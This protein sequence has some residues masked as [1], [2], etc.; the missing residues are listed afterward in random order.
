MTWQD[1]IS[2]KVST[3]ADVVVHRSTGRSPSAPTA[4]HHAIARGDSSSD[5]HHPTTTLIPTPTTAWRRHNVRHL[6]PRQ[7]QVLTAIAT[8]DRIVG[9]IARRLRVTP[10][11]ASATVARLEQLGYVVREKR[12]DRRRTWVCLTSTGRAAVAAYPHGVLP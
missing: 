7:H 9:D 12:F 8:Q 5:P 3:S 11:Y 1:G 2:Q 4:S 10:S 6:T